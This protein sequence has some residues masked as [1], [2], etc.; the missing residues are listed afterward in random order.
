MPL[1]EIPDSY[2]KLINTLWPIILSILGV[3]GYSS[4]RSKQET[5]EA[6]QVVGHQ[7]IDAVHETQAANGA[8]IDSA[9][10]N[11]ED[12]KNTLAIKESKTDAKIEDLTKQVAALPPAVANAVKDKMK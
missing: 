3:L 6:G 9:A 4:L 2:F 1:P 12:V 7:K 8:K 11:A 5:I 10:K